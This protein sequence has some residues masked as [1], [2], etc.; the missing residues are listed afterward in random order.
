MTLSE[1]SGLDL[2]NFKGNFLYTDTAASLEDFLIET[3]HSTLHDQIR[4]TYPSID[5]ITEN[6]GAIGLEAH[7]TNSSLAISDLLLFAPSLAHQQPF[8]GNQN[9]IIRL[10]GTV[11][12]RIDDLQ[13]TDLELSGPGNISLRGSG[14]ITGL[15]NVDHSFF[16]LHLDRLSMSGNDIKDLI[17]AGSI[18]S[19]IRI[20]EFLSMQGTFKG[21]LTSFQTNLNLNSSYG[22]A[23]VNGS[24]KNITSKGR[25]AYD[26]KIKTTHFNLGKLISQEDKIGSITLSANIKGSGTDLKTANASFDSHIDE[27]Q[28]NDYTYHN[29]TVSGT[30]KHGEIV[31]KG[32][33]G[34]PNI[35]LDIE[36]TANMNGQYPTLLLTTNIDTLNLQ[37]LKLYD[38]DLRLHG[39]I[40]ADLATAD[41]EY[42]NGTIDIADLIIGV[43]GNSYKLDTIKIV[44]VATE[45]RDSL[46]VSAEFL[47]IH[48]AGQYNLK[49]IAPALQNTIDQYFNTNPGIDTTVQ[50]DPQQVT[51]TITLIRSP[52]IE[53]LMPE[54]E[55][56][57]DANLSGNFDSSTDEI[58]IKG[59]IPGFSYKEITIHNLDLD[60]HTESNAL[61]YAIT[62]DRINSKQFQVANAS[63]SGKAQ[64]DKLDINLLVKDPEDKE[65][66]KI[67]GQL[68]SLKEQFEF[69]LLPDGLVLNYDPWTVAQD[70]AIQFGNQGLL[71]RDFKISNGQQSMALN[72]NPQQA[73][74]PLDL[75]FTDFQIE[76]LTRL[77]TKDSL[78]AG[79]T[80]NGQGNLRDLK[81]SPVFMGDLTIDDFSFHGDTVGNIALKVN[82]EKSDTY[83]ADIKITGY[84]NEVNLN[85]YYYAGEQSNFDLNMDI[86]KMQLKSVEGFT[87]GQLDDAS[88]TITG[89]LSIKGTFAKPEVRGAVYFHDTGFRITKF[90][91]HFR[92]PDETIQFTAEGIHLD[93]F[94]LIDSAGNEALLTGMVYTSDYRDYRF[95]LRIQADDFQVLNST[96][97]DNELYFGRLFMDTDIR[98]KGGINNPVVDGSLRVND[99][100]VLTV[101][102]PQEDPG[103]VEREGIVQFVDM[104]TFQYT[105]LKAIPDSLNKTEW[106][107]LDIAVSVSVDEDAEFNLIIDEANGDYLHVKGVADLTAGIDPSGKMSLTGR[108]ELHE[109]AYSF[110]FN[111]LKR[112]FLIDKGSTILWTGD[113]MNADVDVTA[114]Y[115]AE[116]APLS[117]VK[118][119]LAE[120][121]QSVINTYKQKLPFRIILT[122]KGK[123]LQPDIT[124]DIDL[125]EK[126]YGV[127]S[128]IV[129]TVQA[130]L[131]ELRT[132]P[133]ELNKQV[134]AVLLLNRFI[135]EDPFQNDARGGG[136]SSL[137]RQS[138]SKLLS[139]Q[140]N[141]LVG[142]L[143]AGVE[144]SF[145]INS[146]EDYT[147]G[148]LQNRT[149]L[150]VGL[151][152]QLL[153]DRLKVSVGSNFELEG[154]QEANRKT[155]NIAGDVS[156]EY[157]LS[158]DGNYLLRAYRKDEYIIVQGQVIETGIGFVFTA[159]YEN[160]KDLFSKKTDEQKFLKKAERQERKAERKAE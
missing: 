85:G 1:S 154:P 126:N 74:A 157:Q 117:L 93:D 31:L 146:M 64:D 110:S 99:K 90:N 138:A 32:K 49:D 55:S 105:I 131:A 155:T 140:L 19:N 12:G 152:K 81:T 28:Y 7:F 60:I 51:F 44:S 79:G 124:F 104:D 73:D 25:E 84:G 158:K 128:E 148:E 118:S 77:V 15:P 10:D 96:R 3:Q 47:R 82:N 8:S 129:S 127:S 23:V 142:G 119:Q 94:T 11:T 36:G 16:D 151:S 75:Q 100:T 153:D 121:D 50:F 120:A 57:E 41:P 159:D 39:R 61:L 88:G 125:P 13:F 139:E 135:A 6:I 62:L 108:Y 150:T 35:T 22:A 20:P 97:E 156:A 37:K 38:K 4:L 43:N 130:K 160:L 2:K 113:A 17:P 29:A 18:P 136:I 144:L 26:M 103:I 48:M 9:D 111:Q 42:L 112:E 34:D 65:Q 68:T 53:E 46:D 80:I 69:R 24:L 72:S 56:M 145:D 67:A 137:A 63:L 58:N 95:D 76:T 78:F 109:G 45:G 14:R 116:T 147:T 92:A 98:V 71:V 83:A 30:A 123:L 21:S 132:Q 134:F 149:D 102:I 101:V 54:L 33:I 115:T 27:L 66:Y 40:V 143:I 114:V 141:N 59:N 91:S 133:S 89:N 106:K 107:G 52:L 70:N 86:V 87:M 122:M 5:S